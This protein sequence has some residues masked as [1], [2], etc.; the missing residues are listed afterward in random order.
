MR[1]KNGKYIKLT[2]A[3]NVRLYLENPK[4]LQKACIVKWHAIKLVHRTQ[5]L[6]IF[7]VFGSHL[8]ILKSD[9]ISVHIINHIW[10]IVKLF[11][12]FIGNNKDLLLISYF[13]EENE[14]Y[15]SLG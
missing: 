15:T 7:L 8:I 9:S 2:Y 1:I 6:S 5:W 4:K 11:L 10:Y 13:I 12:T 3:D 14:Y